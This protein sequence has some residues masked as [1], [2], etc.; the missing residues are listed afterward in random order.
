MAYPREV[1]LDAEVLFSEEGKT[2]AEIAEL[3][4]LHDEARVK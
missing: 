4:G 2:L 3:M 1:K